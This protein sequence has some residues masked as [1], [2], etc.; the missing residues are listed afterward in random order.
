[1][2]R[3]VETENFSEN[4]NLREKSLIEGSAAL[5]MSSTTAAST[6]EFFDQMLCTNSNTK[7][8]IR[9]WKLH[10]DKVS[11]VAESLKENFFSHSDCVFEIECKLSW[12]T[13]AKVRVEN[14]L[15]I[16]N[17]THRRRCSCHYEFS[18]NIK[19]YKKDHQYC[20]FDFMCGWMSCLRELKILLL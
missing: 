6:G 5:R 4:L 3:Q 15:K 19:S 16:E 20:S 10:F 18:W 14:S 8:W 1:M 11:G 13:W 9:L 12:W 17:R 7:S 2:Q